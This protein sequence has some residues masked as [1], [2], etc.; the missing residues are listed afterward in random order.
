MPPLISIQTRPTGIENGQHS[1]MSASATVPPTSMNSTDDYELF[2][3][4]SPFNIFKANSAVT[5]ESTRFG[6]GS[7]ADETTMVWARKG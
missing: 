1:S 2:G 3:S 5:N 6:G 4:V 7:L